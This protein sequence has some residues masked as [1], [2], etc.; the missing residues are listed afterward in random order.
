MTLQGFS[1]WLAEEI[2]KPEAWIAKDDSPS[3]ISHKRTGVF[4]V[5]QGGG[6]SSR[7]EIRSPL[8]VVI[9]GV[10]S[11]RLVALYQNVLIGGQEER[12]RALLDRRQTFLT[13]FTG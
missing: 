10:P 1:D 8:G 2:K 11:S 7:V 5:F 9:L 12:E 3:T 4:F 6:D 13:D